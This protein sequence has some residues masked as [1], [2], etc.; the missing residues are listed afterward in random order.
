MIFPIALRTRNR[1]VY[2]DVTLKSIW[3]T[4]IPSDVPPYI[5]PSYD[6]SYIPPNEPPIK[7]KRRK[8]NGGYVVKKKKR[9][10][11]DGDRWKSHPVE[12]FRRVV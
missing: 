2:L 12:L 9:K 1:P 8:F 11:K 7:S 3:H 6:P 4:N 10:K 5:P